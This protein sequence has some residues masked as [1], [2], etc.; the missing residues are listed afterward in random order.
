M[1]VVEEIAWATT[2]F[3]N[4]NAQAVADVRRSFKMG[5]GS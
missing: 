3:Y 4:R 2:A 1:S 5:E